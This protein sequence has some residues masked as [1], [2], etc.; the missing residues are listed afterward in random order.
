MEIEDYNQIFDIRIQST[1][2]KEK[3]IEYTSE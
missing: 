3:Q 1:T 2:A